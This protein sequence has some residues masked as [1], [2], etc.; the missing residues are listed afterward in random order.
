MPLELT[1]F[2]GREWETTEVKRLLADQRLLTLTGPGGCG[3]TRL[4]LAVA[5][6]LVEDFEDGV[7][8][9]E[10]ASLSDPDL[11]PQAAASALKVREQP[12]R[13]LE[14]TL[15]DALRLK[16]I[17]LVLDNCE[18]LIDATA[19]FVE[20]VLTSCPRLSFLA[21][22]REALG[23]AG[24]TLWPVPSLSLPDPGHPPP[25]EELARYEA[26]RLFAERPKVVV[27]TFEMTEHNAPAMA[28]VCQLLDGIPLAIEL[29]A[30][31]AKVLSVEQIA[32]RLDESFGLLAGGGR[33]AVPHHRTLQATME[34][35][36][37]LLGEEERVLFRRLSVFAG[38]F[39][40][41]AAE[42]V[43]ADGSIEEDGILDLLARLVDKSIV[44]VATHE[45]EE[46]ARYRL[47]ETVRQYGR[48]KLEEAGEAERS[49]SG[50]RGTIWPWPRRPNRS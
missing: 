16:R 2:I 8:L 43:C 30:A 9:V 36:H 6:D 31:R 42:A 11:V 4:A 13:P 1:S 41:G 48:E 39:T 20:T 19:R 17:L 27:P 14:K 5:K 49:R 10:L 28:R 26:I 23:I 35:S 34:W 45:R 29:A 15:V 38:G 47:L 44:V 40:L 50:T 12:G 46:E 33:T 3:K 37:E 24:E 22:S 32:G 18:H 25:V 21:T 7:G